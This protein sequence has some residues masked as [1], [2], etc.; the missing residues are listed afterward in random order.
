MCTFRSMIAL[1]NDRAKSLERFLLVLNWA[2]LLHQ[3]WTSRFRCVHAVFLLDAEQEGRRLRRSKV[4][5]QEGQVT[6]KS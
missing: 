2:A 4:Q 6:C 5:A 3:Q 1:N